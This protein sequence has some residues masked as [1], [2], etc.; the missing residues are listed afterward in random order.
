MMVSGELTTDCLIWNFEFYFD[1][2]TGPKTVFIYFT[3]VDHLA[4]LIAWIFFGNDSYQDL[5]DLCTWAE[6]I[7]INAEN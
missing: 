7:K 4:V 2:N 5:D 3:L 1:D 6:R